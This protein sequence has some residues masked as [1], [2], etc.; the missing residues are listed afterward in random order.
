MAIVRAVKTGVWSDVTVWNTGALPTSADDVYSNTF[1]VTIDT[2]PTVLSISNAATTGVTLGGSF[3]PTNGITLTCTATNGVVTGTTNCIVSSLT[4]GQSCVFTCNIIGAD[5][6]AAGLSHTGNGT[7]T[8][9]GNVSNGPGGGGASGINHGSTAGTLIINGSVSVV[10]GGGGVG[11]CVNQFGTGTLIVNGIVGPV[12]GFTALSITNGSFQIN[13]SVITGAGTAPI[14]VSGG[15]GGFINGSITGGTTSA[16]LL[17]TSSGAIVYHIGTAQ[18]SATYPAIGPGSATQVTILTGP[19]L[20][21]SPNDA[22]AG[23]NPCIALRWFPADTALSTFRYEMRGATASG[24]PSVRPV[25]QLFFTDAYSSG[26]PASNNVNNGSTYG[27]GA[28][29]TGTMNIPNSSAVS[30]GVPVGTTTGTMVLPT[31][32][33]IWN[34]SISDITTSGSIGERLKNAATVETVNTILSNGLR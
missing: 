9:N 16:G 33:S 34:Y 27:P 8:V 1:T 11:F 17:N 26:Y 22:T 6:N 15:T 20:C 31:L 14:Q 3:V 32:Q 13:G 5:G 10:S 19:L 12:G 2:S 4:A 29:Y 18:A 23:V 7:V 21:S 30:L 25:R 28:I 24:S